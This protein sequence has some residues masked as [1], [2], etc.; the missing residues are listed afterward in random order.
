MAPI[1]AIDYVI[2]HELCH[3]KEPTHSAKFWDGV[4]S[5]FPNYQT[6]KEWLRINGRN[7]ELRT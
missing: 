7:L 6:W 4:I 5:L 3:L 2:I 1:S